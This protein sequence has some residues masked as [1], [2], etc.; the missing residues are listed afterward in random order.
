VAVFSENNGAR[1]IGFDTAGTASVVATHASLAP[2]MHTPVATAGRLYAIHRGKIHCLAAA[3]LAPIWTQADRSLKGHAS[4]IASADRV[5]LLTAAG[6]LILLDAGADGFAP[7][8]RQKLF[9]REVSLHAHPAV[10]DRSIY[11]RGPGS[12]LCISL[13]EAPLLPLGS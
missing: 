10:A 1:L 7:L 12:L 5:L 9:A 13:E 6:E 11:V 2:D 3:D 4:I 8:A